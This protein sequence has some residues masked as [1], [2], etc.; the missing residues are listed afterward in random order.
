MEQ[1]NSEYELTLYAFLL[2]CPKKVWSGRGG[3]RYLVNEGGYGGIGIYL[4]CDLPNFCGV[5]H[6]IVVV[7]FFFL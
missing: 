3:F 7:S 5:K 1:Q 2:S 6:E 4:I